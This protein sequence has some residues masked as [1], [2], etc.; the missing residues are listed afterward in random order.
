MEVAELEQRT[1]RMEAISTA[2][3]STPEGTA[4]IVDDLFWFLRNNREID[5]LV[6]ADDAP[7][8]DLFQAFDAAQT[9]IHWCR[10]LLRSGPDGPLQACVTEIK[11]AYLAEGPEIRNF[12]VGAVLEHLFES[13]PMRG[14]FSEWQSDPRLEKAWRDALAWAEHKQMRL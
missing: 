8:G 14:Y 6:L 3:G 9:V 4:S 1:K 13:E 7:E 12:F 11:R 5:S 10:G 2:S